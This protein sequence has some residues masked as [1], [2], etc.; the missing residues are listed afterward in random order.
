MHTVKKLKFAQ[1]QL[2]NPE[3]WVHG[4]VTIAFSAKNAQKHVA[5]FKLSHISLTNGKNKLSPSIVLVVIVVY[6]RS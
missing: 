3:A 2:Q 6:C 5:V 1:G 4:P